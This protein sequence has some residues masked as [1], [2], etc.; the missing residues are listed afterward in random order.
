VFAGG[1]GGGGGAGGAGLIEGGGE[2]A[3]GN[4]GGGGGAEGN[5]GG[6]GGGAGGGAFVLTFR[7]VGGGGGGFPATRLATDEGLDSGFGGGFFK[8]A[9]GLGIAGAE[10]MDPGNGGLKLGIAGAGIDGGR[11][12]A[13]NGG[14]GG[15]GVEVSESECAP[16]IPAPVSM[17]PRVFLS[18]GMPP[19]RSPASW[20]GPSL[21]L[22]GVV[23]CPA[24]L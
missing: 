7:E 11:G 13:P 6:G 22:L 10:S 18:L 24:S 5:E 2:G 14:R 23:S 12:A 17:P 9:S 3:E 4:D 15:A 19:A 16:S 20:G 21:K 8:F 1:G